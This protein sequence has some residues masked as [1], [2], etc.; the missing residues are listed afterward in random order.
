LSDT[1]VQLPLSQ[2]YD[3]GR[4]GFVRGGTTT[5]VVSADN[6]LLLSYATLGG[7][8]RNCAGGVTPWRTWI[9]C[10]ETTL[11]PVTEPRT[12]KA[13]GYCFEVRAFAIVPAEPVPLRAMGR[14]SHEAVA[15]DPRTGIIY[16]TEDTN[17]SCF[18]RFILNK[19]EDLRAGG[20][21]EAMRLLEFLKGVNTTQNFPVGV[22]FEVDWVP[23]ANVDPSDIDIPVNVQAQSQGAA[24]IRRGEGIFWNTTDQAMYF[25]ATDGGG[26]RSGQIFKYTPL[27]GRGGN[28]TLELFVEAPAPDTET[29]PNE[30]QW[31]DNVAAT[32]WGDLILCEDGPTNQHLY[33][34]NAARK[35]SR[36][37]RNVLNRT[38][39]AGACFSADGRTLF[40]N[41]YGNDTLPG[42]TVAITGP[43]QPDVSRSRRRP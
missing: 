25:A 21:L 8:I 14:F 35:V 30:W 7:T 1:G 42:L 9:T 36:F 19:Q 12:T 37:A 5:L 17:S 18:Y 16:E 3:P 22:E 26:A 24:I 41:I 10:E 43:W 39:F 28:G 15:V 32:P 34:L 20:R 11:T 33:I 38:E 2:R 23:I 31:P 29:S 40:V 4:S 13:H 27:K 6:E